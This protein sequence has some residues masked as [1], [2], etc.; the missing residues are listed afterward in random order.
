MTSRREKPPIFASLERLVE[1][2]QGSSG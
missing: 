1:S 2:E